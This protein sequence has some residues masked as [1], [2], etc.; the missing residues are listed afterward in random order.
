MVVEDAR[1]RH[2]QLWMNASNYR[3]C[4]NS[5]LLQD[6]DQGLAVEIPYATVSVTVERMLGF[7]Q[8]VNTPEY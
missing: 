4:K 1:R 3:R 2:H 8:S 7:T 5:Y 6:W